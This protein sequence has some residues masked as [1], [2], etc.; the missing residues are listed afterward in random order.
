[1][2]LDME[3]TM[4]TDANMQGMKLLGPNLSND[5]NLQTKYN[6]ASQTKPSQNDINLQTK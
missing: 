2:P 3:V 1:M 5:I 6:G 4:V